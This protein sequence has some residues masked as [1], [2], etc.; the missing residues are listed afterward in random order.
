MKMQVLY[1]EKQEGKQGNPEVLAEKIAREYKCKSDKIPPA[2]PCDNERLVFIVFDKYGSKFD[3][4]LIA[5]CKDLSTARAQNVAL[6]CINNDGNTE[7]A[8]LEEIFKANGVG[9]A[10]KKGI[11]LKKGLFSAA[12]AGEAEKNEVLAFA[13][14]IVA[15]YFETAVK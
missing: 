12:K 14:D 13:N 3:K 10:A 6:V 5:F 9:V 11:A 7:C 8:E 15:K 4:K 2:Y 1:T